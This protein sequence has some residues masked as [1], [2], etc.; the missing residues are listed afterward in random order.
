MKK[1]GYKFMQRRLLRAEL[2]YRSEHEKRILAEGRIQLA[3]EKA[4]KLRNRIRSIGQ[5]METI[6]K[7]INEVRCIEWTLNP[8]AWGQ[9]VAL[10]PNMDVIPQEAME[11]VKAELAM[12]IVE[13][14]E[15][16]GLIQYVTRGGSLSDPLDQAVSIGAKIYI[17]PWE[18]M[19]HRRS[20][21]LRELVNEALNEEEGL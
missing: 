21:K 2:R 7:D 6:D 8:Q 19:P 5:N 18:Q 17:V 9:Y 16:N 15:K 20:I 14:A 1:K 11:D 4:E 10:T 13:G 3:E 12:A